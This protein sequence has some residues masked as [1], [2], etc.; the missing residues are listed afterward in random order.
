MVRNGWKAS[1]APGL[2][3]CMLA[4]TLP[5]H[6]EDARQLPP[7]TQE[8]V[9]GIAQ[10]LMQVRDTDVELSCGKAADNARSG[11]ETMLEVGQKNM[12][13]GYMKRDDY[14]AAASGLKALLSQLSESDCQGA[15]GVRQAFYR[16]MSSDANHVIAC[17]A[18][19][20]F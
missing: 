8:A 20:R 14:E 1:I 16:C 9:A 15:S 17:A 5:A 11:V 6:A 3:A 18:A 19:H 13:A 10:S 2:L 4:T 7:Q 12:D